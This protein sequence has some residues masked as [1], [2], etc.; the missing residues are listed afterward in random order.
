MKKLAIFTLFC[1]LFLSF[2]PAQE[3]DIA[4]RVAIDSLSSS[5]K[6]PL[7][8][9]ISPITMT[10]TNA[11]SE[12]S[13][14]L[15]ELITNHA[16]SNRIFSVVPSVP[17]HSVTQAGVIGGSFTLKNDVLD[18]S[19]FVSENGHILSSKSFSISAR[20]LE[21]WYGIA[22]EPAN[23]DKLLERERLFAGLTLPVEKPVRIQAWFNS[24]SMTYL[25]REPLDITVMSDR[26]C[27]FKVVL[28]DV[29]NNERVIFPYKND[30]DNFLRANT[31]RAVF[32]DSSY[33]LY[34][35]YGAETIL[36]I[37]SVNQFDNIRQDYS[38]A[39][40]PATTASIKNAVANNSAARYDITI[41]TPQ[42]EH[43]F[44]LPS[45]MSAEVQSF[46]SDIK[47][48]GG[49]FTGDVTSGYFILN[50]IRNSY[51]TVPQ[52]SPNS[53][54]YVVYNDGA[55]SNDRVFGRLLPYPSLPQPIHEEPLP[56][57]S[58][59]RQERIASLSFSLKKPKNLSQAFEIVKRGILATKGGEFNGDTSSGMFKTIHFSGTLLAQYN[60][61]DMINIDIFER[62]RGASDK[63]IKSA[64]E[65]KFKGL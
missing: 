62:P 10:G 57:E 6:A 21:W 56:R 54:E 1:F 11:P 53:I 61:T 9:S 45:D 28:I 26:D 4:I 32:K 2:L 39:P 29:N 41:L 25:H 17:G 51:R 18:V 65:E 7:K 5:L 48:Q 24:G 42:E 34:S 13:R 31:Q 36:V 27:Y 22:I 46:E 38:A 44:A 14:L 16:K 64:I 43:I 50:G 40:R 63:M 12:L 19:L 47:D 37:A 58:P 3:I 20:E 59:S 15:N 8:V 52:G 60:V 33:M 49:Q 30:E 55:W 35:P 23:Q